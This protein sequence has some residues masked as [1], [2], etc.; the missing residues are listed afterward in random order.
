MRALS[1]RQATGANLLELR[2]AA[3]GWVLV[4]NRW[5]KPSLGRF[6]KQILASLGAERV[7]ELARAFD[8]ATR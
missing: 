1:P 6:R 5:V 2:M 8:T 3:L 4:R 7:L